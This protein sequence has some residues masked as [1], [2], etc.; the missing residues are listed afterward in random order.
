[1]YE[2]GTQMDETLDAPT[3]EDPNFVL[4][5]IDAIHEDNWPEFEAQGVR[6][7][8][9]DVTREDMPEMLGF[10]QH[11]YGV[12]NVYTGDAFDEKEG[13]P[14]RHKPGSAIYFHPDGLEYAR[15]QHQEF[16]QWMRDRERRQASSGGGPASS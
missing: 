6:V 3:E 9:N 16:M 13:R 4:P 1:M 8:Y 7:E 5:H 10:V 14:L 11:R 12:E 15:R 2:T